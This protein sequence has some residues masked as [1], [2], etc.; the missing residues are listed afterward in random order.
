MVIKKCIQYSVNDT[1]DNKSGD[2]I[3]RLHHYRY[4]K[5][6]YYSTIIERF[7]KFSAYTTNPS[8]GIG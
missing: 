2:V 1:N 3:M 4:T 8:L 6:I 5:I 7:V